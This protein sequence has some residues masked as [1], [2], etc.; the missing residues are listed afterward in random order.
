LLQKTPNSDHIIPEYIVLEQY[1]PGQILTPSIPETINEPD[2]ITTSDASDVEMEQSFSTMVMESV[3]DQPSSSY[4]QTPTFT[5]SQPSSSLD[6]QPVAPPKPT[7]IPS[8]PTIFLDSTLLQDVYENLGQE[9]VKL[10]QARN[11]LVHRES[12]EQQWRRPNER[13][14]YVMSELQRTCIDDQASA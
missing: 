4:T 6:I 13:V 5:N 14:D 8:P 7:K 9:L 11:D 1:V 3:P 2:F 12:Y 10:I